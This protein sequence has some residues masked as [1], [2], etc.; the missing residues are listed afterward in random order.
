MPIPNDISRTEL[1]VL[2]REYDRVDGILEALYRYIQDANDVNRYLCIRE[3][4]KR[5]GVN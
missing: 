5:A 2:L 3:P 1:F 4:G